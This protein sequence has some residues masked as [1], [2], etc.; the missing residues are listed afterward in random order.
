MGND[1]DKSSLPIEKKQDTYR[2]K[3]KLQ[4]LSSDNTWNA[5]QELSLYGNE[6]VLKIYEKLRDILDPKG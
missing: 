4:Q 3:I 2:I 5:I 6:E 1:T